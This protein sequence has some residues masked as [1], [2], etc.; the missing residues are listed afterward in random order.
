MSGKRS[1]AEA[2]ADEPEAKAQKTEEEAAK[3]EEA[4]AADHDAAEAGENK[5]DAAPARRSTRARNPARKARVAEDKPAAATKG[6]AEAKTAQV[7]YKEG[8]P[9][10]EHLKSEGTLVEVK[11]PAECTVSTNQQVRARTRRAPRRALAE[12]RRSHATGS[13]TRGEPDGRAERECGWRS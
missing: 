6:G 3:A 10:T 5:D 8:E 7:T 13:G 2:P 1:A 9:L 11:I 12:R 4:E